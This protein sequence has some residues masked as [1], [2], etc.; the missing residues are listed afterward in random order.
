VKLTKERKR[1]IRLKWRNMTRLERKKELLKRRIY[2]HF[3]KGGITLDR[4][5][6][7]KVNFYVED[8]ASMDWAFFQAVG[9]EYDPGCSVLSNALRDFPACH[10]QKRRN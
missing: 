10:R 2:W 6:V 1:E 8:L 5:L 9:L 4:E 7:K 3:A